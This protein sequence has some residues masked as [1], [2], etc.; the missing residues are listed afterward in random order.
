MSFSKFPEEQVQAL[1]AFG[2]VKEFCNQYF[3]KEQNQILFGMF[4]P[5]IIC[6]KN[7]DAR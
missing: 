2:G 7:F 6:S 4:D 3:A 5:R 1:K